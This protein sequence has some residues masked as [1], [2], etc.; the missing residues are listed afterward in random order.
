MSYREKEIVTLIDKTFSVYHL[1]RLYEDG[2]IQFLQSITEKVTKK[3]IA[4]VTD[5]IEAI[6]QGIPMPV[7]YVSELQNGDFLILGSEDRLLYLLEYIRGSFPVCI[8]DVLKGHQYYFYELEKRNPWLSAMILR[9]VFMFRIIDYQTPKYLHMEVGL[10]HERWNVSQEQ[11]V[12]NVLYSRNKVEKLKCIS[13][14]VMYTIFGREKNKEE[15]RNEYI[16][17]Y[18]MLFWGVYK[19]RL[20]IDESMKEQEL[21]DVVISTLDES[22]YIWQGFLQ[23]IVT[24]VSYFR[25]VPL[26]EPIDP[27]CEKLADKDIRFRAKMFG[28]FICLCDQFQDKVILDSLYDKKTMRKMKTMKLT[29][30]NMNELFRKDLI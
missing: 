1:I 22:G 9:T 16:T 11:A 29:M 13:R 21:L 14:E 30:K 15:H 20:C 24:I 4:I 6:Q 27:F 18:M 3:N 25:P 7:V 12:R 19:N 2:N 26:I 28:L 8:D 10:F 5:V 17:L 23:K